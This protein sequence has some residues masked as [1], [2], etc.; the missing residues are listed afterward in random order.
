LRGAVVSGQKAAA[1][2]KRLGVTLDYQRT[3]HARHITIYPPAGMVFDKNLGLECC[4]TNVSSTKI[5]G[6]FSSTIWG[7]S[8]PGPGSES[9]KRS[10]PMGKIVS[11]RSMNENHLAR[12]VQALLVAFLMWSQEDRL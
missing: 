2:A 6:P 10:P 8:R 12:I 5:S 11:E 4:T 3:R 7:R 9:G 1:P